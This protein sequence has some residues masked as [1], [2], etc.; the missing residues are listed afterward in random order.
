MRRFVVLLSLFSVLTCGCVSFLVG[1]AGIVTGYVAF[2]DTVAGNLDGTFDEVWQG[3]ITVMESRT[4]II[5]E[6]SMGGIVKAK[7]GNND[8]IVKV[9]TFTDNAYKIKVTCRKM[10]KMASNLELAQDLFT[11]MI[12]SITRIQAEAG[13]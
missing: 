3:I 12:K 4:E 1:A 10:Y 7:Y 2:K 11:R 6:N 5:E 8:I 9:I 13:K